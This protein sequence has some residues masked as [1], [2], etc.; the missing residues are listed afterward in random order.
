MNGESSQAPRRA[1]KRQV[2]V[3]DDE[4][5]GSPVMNGSA[6]KKRRAASSP[7]LEDDDL[8]ELTDGETPR[9]KKGK[10][11]AVNGNRNGDHHDDDGEEDGDEAMMGEDGDVEEG[12]GEAVRRAI[13]YRPEYDRDDDG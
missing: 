7:V 2:I 6:K 10:G 5:D 4:S 1:G 11:R 3:S 9:R 12:E 8:D 13:G